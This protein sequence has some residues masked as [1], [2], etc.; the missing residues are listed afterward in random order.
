[1]NPLL[2]DYTSPPSTYS[3]R[4]TTIQMVEGVF[5]YHNLG[6]SCLDNFVF[7]IARLFEALK[8]RLNFVRIVFVCAVLIEF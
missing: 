3:D 1:V 2:V 8:S 5:C 6:D 4:P 7:E